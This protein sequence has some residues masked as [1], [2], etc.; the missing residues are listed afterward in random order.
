[1]TVIAS[2]WIV[3]IAIGLKYLFAIK[4]MVFDIS[5]GKVC[6]EDFNMTLMLKVWSFVTIVI[7]WIVPL[8]VTT[9]LYCAIGVTLLGR[10]KGVEESK[11]IGKINGTT[12]PLR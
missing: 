12:K 6:T 5:E 9:V 3:A 7:I 11:L 4:L 8:I 10:H 1:M 2:T